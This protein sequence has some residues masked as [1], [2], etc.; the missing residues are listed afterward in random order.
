IF[1]VIAD[2]LKSAGTSPGNYATLAGAR[3][4]LS[5]AWSDRKSATLVLDECDFVDDVLAAL[6]IG[7][8][9]AATKRVLFTSQLCPASVYGLAIPELTSV[10]AMALI[11]PQIERAAWPET[12]GGSPLKIQERF[13]NA[14][15]L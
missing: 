9:L 10:Q 1:A 6:G 15:L 13:A 5:S 2:A 11:G 12:L 4:G 3:L 8:G 7:G 14:E